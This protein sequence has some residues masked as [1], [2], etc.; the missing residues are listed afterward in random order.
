MEDKT[1]CAAF[2]Q[3]PTAERPGR[4]HFGGRS[5]W[6]CFKQQVTGEA[7]AAEDEYFGCVSIGDFILCGKNP[8]AMGAASYV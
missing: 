8:L 1:V 6:C 3:W 7:T 5:G 2:A 4:V